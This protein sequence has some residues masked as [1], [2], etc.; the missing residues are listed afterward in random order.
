MKKTLRILVAVALAVSAGSVFGQDCGP[1]NLTFRPQSIDLFPGDDLYDQYVPMIALQFG[2]DPAV[3]EWCWTQRVVGTIQGRWIT[4]G[5]MGLAMFDPFGLGGGP[6]MYGNPGIITSK[7]GVIYT[8][9][10][11]LS[12]YNSEGDWVAFGGLTW[13]GDGTGR[14][15]GADGWGTDSP[16]HYPPSF[17]VRSVGFLCKPE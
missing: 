6:D 11:G 3:F 2:L 8:M 1:L 10:Y 14:Y 15:T 9:S 16:K 4:C 17:W 13:Y 7:K 12:K 5:G